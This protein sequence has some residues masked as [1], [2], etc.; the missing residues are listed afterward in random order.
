MKMKSGLRGQFW[1]GF[2]LGLTLICAA[3]EI[4]RAIKGYSVPEIFFALTKYVG[5][6]EWLEAYQTLITGAVALVAAILSVQA[7]RSQIDASNASTQKQIDH[8]AELERRRL[9]AKRDAARAMLPM[10]LTVICEYAENTARLLIH[11]IDVCR[12]GRL[13][14]AYKFPEFPTVPSEA[15]LLL[16]DVIEYSDPDRRIVFAK[17]IQRIQILSSRIR[18]LPDESRNT[19]GVSELNLEAYLVDSALI[20]AQASDLFS[21]ARFE[22]GV[23]NTT[24]NSSEIKTAFSLLGV[25]DD[26]RR[27]RLVEQA[28]RTAAR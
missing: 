6:F 20:Y 15:L 18:G 27:G 5:R 10:A 4:L 8:D 22:V 2:G 25:Y 9:D 24:I 11:Q 14:K 3:I 19:R 12:N 23:I 16:R 13:E 1:L 7:I 28:L 26:E 17:L 21:Y